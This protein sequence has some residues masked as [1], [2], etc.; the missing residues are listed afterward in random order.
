MQGD[1][2]VAVL[3]RLEPRQ[4]GVAAC[5]AKSWRLAAAEALPPAFVRAH[6]LAGVSRDVGAPR[7]PGFMETASL[8]ALSFARL[9]QVRAL[10]TGQ[11]GRGSG[12]AAP[13]PRI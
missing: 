1:V 4:L 10:S 5:V 12:N 3:S 2:L 7:R 8:G 11:L 13:P 9:H 6:C